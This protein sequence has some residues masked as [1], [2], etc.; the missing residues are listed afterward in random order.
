MQRLAAALLNRDP[1]A[2][3]G[4][5]PAPATSAPAAIESAPELADETKAEADEEDEATSASRPRLVRRRH[6]RSGANE[7]LV[8]AS[9][10]N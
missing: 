8:A 2:A 1:L 5:T 3:L 7:A 9:V 4:A 6:L 10:L